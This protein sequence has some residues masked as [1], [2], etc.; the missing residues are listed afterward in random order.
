MFRPM[1]RLRSAGSQ[2]GRS[3]SAFVRFVAS[4]TRERKALFV[5]GLFP[6]R[7]RTGDF[8][9]FPAA[10]AATSA[11]RRILDRALCRVSGAAGHLLFHL[12]EDTSVCV[13]PKLIIIYEDGPRRARARS[14][15]IAVQR[16]DISDHCNTINP[17]LDRGLKAVHYQ[18][19]GGPDGGETP[20]C[21]RSH[22]LKLDEN[23]API[24]RNACE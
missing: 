18:I 10:A 9:V 20:L 7:S 21:T 6:D 5:D 13:R 24:K 11:V 22:V 19:S 15:S 16:E 12:F 8:D 3:R 4:K 1:P 14:G 2:T 17:K 23:A